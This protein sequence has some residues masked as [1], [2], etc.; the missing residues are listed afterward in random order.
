MIDIADVLDRLDS[1]EDRWAM[2][3]ITTGLQSVAQSAEASMESTTAHGDV[4]GATRA[5]YRS[6]VV[7][8]E[9]SGLGVI[10]GALAAVESRN[11]GHGA[12]GGGTLA[13]QVGVVFTCPTDYQRYLET[14]NAG[15]RAVLGPTLLSYAD[16]CTRHAAEGK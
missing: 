6:Y 3:R 9:D 10:G 4:T 8:P 11:P 2:P 13:G 1:L 16:D 7:T 12:L 15:K 5:G 14:E